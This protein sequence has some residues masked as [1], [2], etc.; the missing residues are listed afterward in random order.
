VTSGAPGRVLLLAFLAAS[1]ALQHHV[2]ELAR[3]SPAGKPGVLM[4]KQA[5]EFSLPDTRGRTVALADL[6]RR[7]PVL[8]DFF[9]VDCIPCR[10][11]WAH[12]KSI[13][14]KATTPPVSV[15]AINLGDPPDKLA[16]FLDKFQSPFPVLKG[17]KEVSTAYDVQAV[18]RTLLVS[19][20]GSVVYD[21]V[22]AQPGLPMIVEFAIR[23]RP[24]PAG[25]ARPEGRHPIKGGGR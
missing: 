5:P 16:T 21:M 6:R 14:S 19:G 13:Q 8:V 10:K 23:D 9:I 17:T 3:S 7:G 4:G 24:A 18:P 12:L 15:L 1:V 20:D 11:Q 25:S 22:G 2:K